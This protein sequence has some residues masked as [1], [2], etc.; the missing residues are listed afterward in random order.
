M[1][2]KPVRKKKLSSI[3][4]ATKFKLQV[5][6]LFF[7]LSFLFFIF[8]SF[9]PLSPSICSCFLFFSASVIVQ[10]ES[11]PFLCMSWVL[12]GQAA[13]GRLVCGWCFCFFYMLI[14]AWGSVWW[15][16][17]LWVSSSST[18]STSIVLVWECV[19][20]FVTGKRL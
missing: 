3:S 16:S 19:C 8:L 4:S 15:T 9:L 12:M 18:S 11:S 2:H 13:D 6:V 20:D 14:Y 5:V 1:I 10:R 17:V 7:D